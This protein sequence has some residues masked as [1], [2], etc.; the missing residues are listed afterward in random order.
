MTSFDYDLFVIGAGSGGVRAARVAA[1]LGARVAI[2]EEDRVGGT[3]VIRGCVPKKLFVTASHFAEAFEDAAGF[4]WTVEGLRFDWPTLVANVAADV[5]WLSGVYV[6]NLEKSGADLIR[7]R[8]VLEDAHRLRLSAGDRV[9]SAGKILVATGGAPTVERGIPGIEHT[10]TSNDVF[11][12]ERL[13]ERILIM[14]G[15]YIAVEF[16]GVFNGLGSETHLA[17]RADNVLRGFDEEVRQWVRA[18]M[19]HRGIE[20]ISGD[21]IA[22]IE[23]DG[24]RLTGVMR[25]GR[26]IE[27]DQILMALGRT[28]AARG[29]G[30]EEAGVAI[31]REGAI[32]VDALSMTNVEDIYAIGDVTNRKRLTPVAIREGAA[33]AETAFGGKPMVVD[34]VDIPTAVFSQPEMGTVGLTEEQAKARYPMVDIYRANFKPLPNRVS[35]RNERMLIKLVVDGAT[36]RLLGCHIVGPSASELAQ[37]V[38]VPM[39]MGATKAD[40]DATVA[41]HPTLAEENVTIPRP[42]ER[43]RRAAAE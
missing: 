13:P 31:D 37:L 16:A 2:A 9:V 26:R 27:V 11:H 20:V 32:T 30:L 33:F 23:K 24:G 29:L 8:A 14:G 10:I 36:D 6:R 35:G 19:E 39:K 1:G 42:V 22:A 38:A 7:S 34:Y 25:S 5:E 21:M 28:P 4:G 17:C 41:I 43:H 3:C 40:F 18:G 12:L 15:G